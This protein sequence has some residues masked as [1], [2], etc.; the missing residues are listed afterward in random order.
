ML[1]A[2]QHTLAAAQS[3]ATVL[4]KG[5]DPTWYSAEDRTLVPAT[6]KTSTGINTS[7]RHN[8][9]SNGST[10]TT[11]DFGWLSDMFRGMLSFI[12]DF[13][14]IILTIVLIAVLTLIV[15]FLIRVQRMID[16]PG[17]KS[18]G[19]TS[20]ATQ[21]RKVTDLP[22]ELDRPDLPLL[23]LVEQYRNQGEFSKAIIYLYSYI[24]IE[25]DAA[26]LVRLA[27]GKTNW[28]YLSE[29]N[30][31]PQE[32]SLTTSV[33]YWFEHI[34]FGK[35]EMDAAAFDAIWSAMPAFHEGLKA[36]RKERT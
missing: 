29:L 15:F 12:R 2:C 1:L 34:F 26:G 19:N 3:D 11:R 8:Q 5:A 16:P 22:F 27:K 33:V 13:W 28:T 25:L 23:Q 24:L 17:S 4:S 21:Q 36:I 30:P 6:P 9:I 7:D 20:V 10:K 35:Q 31:R 14:K 18:S 32:K